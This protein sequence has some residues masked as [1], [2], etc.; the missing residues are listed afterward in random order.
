MA[1]HV[2]T[3]CENTFFGRI[4]ILVSSKWMTMCDLVHSTRRQNPIPIKA[5]IMCSGVWSIFF[6]SVNSEG[7][8]CSVDECAR[9]SEQEEEIF[10]L[11][12]QFFFYSEFWPIDT[13]VFVQRKWIIWMKI[14]NSDFTRKETAPLALGIFVRA[15]LNSA[16]PRLQLDETHSCATRWT[17]EGERKTIRRFKQSICSVHNARAFVSF[18]FPFFSNL[19][20]ISCLTSLQQISVYKPIPS[21][22]INFSSACKSERTAATVLNGKLRVMH[23]TCSI[24]ARKTDTC[25]EIRW[26]CSWNRCSSLLTKAQTEPAEM[27][28][29]AKRKPNDE[30]E[31]ETNKW[32]MFS[33]TIYWICTCSIQSSG[34]AA[35]ANAL[36]AHTCAFR[37]V[38]NYQIKICMIL[39]LVHHWTQLNISDSFPMFLSVGS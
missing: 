38:L 10:L 25:T 34:I 2:C 31:R 8:W 4:S 39:L 7:F 24:A 22:F 28:R 27:D 6:V 29:S 17:S 19:L 1:K 35:S 18:C 14:C 16:C 9:A 36:N 26:C 33:A 11:C 30:R 3:R 20:L 23:T 13:F 5:L 37:A 21:Y 32:T 12:S 15:I